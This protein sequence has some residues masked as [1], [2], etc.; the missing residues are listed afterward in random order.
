MTTSTSITEQIQQILNLYG[1]GDY[2]EVSRLASELVQ[3]NPQIPFGWKALGASLKWLGRTAESLESYREALKLDKNDPE[4]YSNMGNT[5]CELGEL[6]EAERFCREAIKIKPLFAEAYNNLGNTLKKSGRLAESEECYRKAIEIRPVYAH[7]NSNLGGLL[8]LLGKYQQAEKYCLLAIEYDPRLAD[9]Y[10]N[11][12]NSYQSL[13]FQEKALKQYTKALEVDKGNVE[14]LNNVSIICRERGEYDVAIN[15][16]KAI[17]ER[18]PDSCL[19]LVNLGA[20]LREIGKTEEAR[21]YV[22]KALLINQKSPDALATLGKVSIDIGDFG[23]A[24]KYFLKALE[25]DSGYSRAISGLIQTRKMNE[26]DR[27]ILKTC[28]RMISSGMT[29]QRESELR[30]AMGKL[31]DDVRD[32]DSAFQHYY[33]A[34]ELKKRFSPKYN[35][36]EISGEIDKTIID[37]SPDKLRSADGK[38]SDSRKPV[39]IVG[40]PRSGTSL[41]EQILAS[42]PNIHGAGELQ[43]WRKLMKDI[44]AEKKNFFDDKSRAEIAS[45]CLSN[46]DSYSSDALRVV[47]KT[48]TNYLYLGYIHAIFPK[49]KII[50]LYRNPLDTCL[51]IFFQNFGPYH[52]YANDLNDISH[53]YQSY[54]KLMEHWHKVLPNDVL[55]DVSYEDV[56]DDQEKLSKRI[57][58]FLDLPWDNKCLKYFETSR[59]VGTASN[60]QVRQPIY[61]SSK[62]RWRNYEAHISGAPRFTT[63]YNSLKPEHFVL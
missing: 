11:L 40:M 52:A 29:V 17:L 47:D 19:A 1:R 26:Q 8:N 15:N 7:A 22:E 45:Q 14:A 35:R 37:F 48:P 43:F 30:F 13:G 50:H 16:F 21:S 62:E 39:F 55:L 42:H 9:A 51:S 46:L 18:Y 38:V 44:G 34:N 61:K 3:N 58:E 32:Y 60:W 6:E 20:T 2:N 25:Y 23:S 63:S 24:E 4:I 31:C 33:L 12:G 56:V 57:I 53:Y 27:E 28:E 36:T 5:L 10:N 54:L 59:K 41:I 49:A